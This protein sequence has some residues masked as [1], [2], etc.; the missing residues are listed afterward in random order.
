VQG[1]GFSLTDAQNGVNF[2]LDI[3]GTPE[4]LAWPLAGSDD[5]WLALDRNGNGM[6]DNG[7][8]LFGNHTSQP[9]P[10]LG[11]ARNGF[12]AL[13][14]FD[15]PESGGNGDGNITKADAVFSSLRLWQDANHNG[16]SE[17]NEL[18]SL[19]ELGLSAIELDYKLSKRRD[20]YG[21]F[22]RYR[23]KIRDNH[24]AQMGRWAWDVILGKE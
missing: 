17:A 1:N 22:F 11:Y 8:E 7:G 14:V 16:F 18:H 5:A 9:E 13:A 2:D 15:K 10:E 19:D 21:N 12:R 24:D 23:A 6:I 3:D 4:R 20:S